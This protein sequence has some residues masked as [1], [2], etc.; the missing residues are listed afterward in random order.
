MPPREKLLYFVVKKKLKIMVCV[1]FYAT[2]NKHVSANKAEKL[3]IS[4]AMR[5][6]STDG[7]VAALY[8]SDPGS[9]PVVSMLQRY[10]KY[11]SM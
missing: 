5:R 9:N 1:Q 3:T 2:V 10:C 4:E 6:D 8:P 11:Y 7:R